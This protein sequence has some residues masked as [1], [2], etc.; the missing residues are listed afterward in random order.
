MTVDS[1]FLYNLSRVIPDCVNRRFLIGTSDYSSYVTKWPNVKRSYDNIS[2]VT[3]TITLAN[4]DGTFNYFRSSKINIVA[5]CYLYLEAFENKSIDVYSQN[6]FYG[7][8]LL[9]NSDY[10]RPGARTNRTTDTQ[11]SPNSDTAGVVVLLST[12]DNG[13]NEK[14]V[15]TVTSADTGGARV[16]A[17]YSGY[18]YTVSAFFKQR[19]SAVDFGYISL[20]NA[21]GGNAVRLFDVQNGAIAGAVGSTLSNTSGI[22]AWPGGWYKCWIRF[23]NSSGAGTTTQTLYAEIGMSANSGSTTSG[24]ASGQGI[25]LYGPQVTITNSPV[26]YSVSCTTQVNPPRLGQNLFLYSEMTDQGSWSKSQS[27]VVADYAKSPIDCRTAADL[28]VGNNGASTASL[29]QQF[30]SA[31]SGNYNAVSMYVKLRDDVA[32]TSMLSNWVQLREGANGNFA[33]FN[34]TVGSVS[35]LSTLAP[36]FIESADN[37]WWR[38]TACTTYGGTFH[39]G[40]QVVNSDGTAP[41]MTTNSIHG[42][43]VFG[44]MSYVA[45]AGLTAAPPY[46]PTSTSV[47]TVAI[48][49]NLRMS[50]GVSTLALVGS[51]QVFVGKISKVKY[52][53]NNLALS[54]TDKLKQL[55][56][57]VMGST[58]NP[59]AYLSSNYL[60]SDIAWWSVVS[61][62]GW[63]SVQS[64]S[65]PDID[66]T[67]FQEWAAIFSGDN[68][69]VQA[70]FEGS[71]VTAT[72]RKIQRMT[73]SAIFMKNNK[74]SFKRFTIANSEFLNLADSNVV[75]SA[76]EI[77][78]TQIINKQYVFANYDVSSDIFA[79]TVFIQN[80][81]STNSYGLREEI[82]KDQSIWYTT[83]ANA[84]NLAER[85]I[86]LRS[87][88]Y[89][90]VDI[91]TNLSGLLYELGDMVTLTDSSIGLPIQPYRI[92]GKSFNM[93]SCVIDFDAQ[94][95]QSFDAFILDQS[96]LDG[97]SVLT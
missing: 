71:K 80:T 75:D 1:S 65:N 26:N 39:M 10:W 95:N 62:G 72:L 69:Y 73:D 81:A 29:R 32:S 63:S 54:M 25:Y 91:Q 19:D 7:S 3:A 5:D 33:Y 67:A 79:T 48:A 37:G 87:N 14:F 9:T 2:P 12:S 90:R 88:P 84:Q 38:I 11:L 83:S 8:A 36:A 47:G 45:S 89:E 27:F 35:N 50:C 77:D 43:Y 66:Y 23:D 57:R 42:F 30:V 18:Q 49:P 96:L 51:Y 34:V 94:T 97:Q 22:E 64:T 74:L 85:I 24:V 68:I 92:T 46:V 56:E 60:P 82:E 61:Y 6:M 93:D 20:S 52:D 58:D 4:Q 76:L 17:I 31:T 53:N 70:R 59:V 40:L 13:T 78:E 55:S 44:G 21:D 15:R 41:F 86:F 28:W 16:A